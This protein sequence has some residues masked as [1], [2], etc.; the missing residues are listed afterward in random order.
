MISRIIIAA[1]LMCAIS[2]VEAAEENS[3]FPAAGIEGIS[4]KIPAGEITL[5]GNETNEIHVEQ[6]FTFNGS[7]NSNRENCAVTF[8][9]YSGV[10]TYIASHNNG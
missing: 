7:T 4:I 10:L 1:A 5:V 3:T 8:K 2:L 6:Q 9:T